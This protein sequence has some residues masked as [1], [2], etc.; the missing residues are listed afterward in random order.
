MKN[1]ILS[2]DGDYMLYSVPDAVADGLTGYC[3]EFCTEWLWKSPHAEKYR[4][5]RHGIACVCYNE[6]DFIAYLNQWVFPQEPSV[7][8]KHLGAQIP[9]EYKNFPTFHF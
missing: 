2:A 5:T 6:E 9:K 3:M 8:L 7:L 1:V 4:R